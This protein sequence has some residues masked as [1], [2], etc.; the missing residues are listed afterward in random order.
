MKTG[1]LK[2]DSNTKIQVGLYR[3]VAKGFRKHASDGTS[4]QYF[5]SHR[6][7]KVFDLKQNKAK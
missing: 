6:W 7:I 2:N 3:S 4:F 1:A 5:L